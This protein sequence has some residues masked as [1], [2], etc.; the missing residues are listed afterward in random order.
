M[1]I[2][3]VIISVLAVILFFSCFLAPVKTEAKMGGSNN[4]IGS[5]LKITR[6]QFLNHLYRHSNDGYYLGTR[7]FS[8]SNWINLIYPNGSPRY[9]GFTGMNCAGWVSRALCDAGA[10]LNP[11][12]AWSDNGNGVCGA[13]T[14]LNYVA[15]TNTRY[16]VYES[17]EEMIYDG[18]LRKGDIIMSY[19]RVWFE[20]ADTHI[21][22]FWGNNAYDDKIWHQ[23]AIGNNISEIRAGCANSR[24][25][26]FP[27]DAVINEVYPYD[28]TG[29]K[30]DEYYYAWVY[31]ENGKI[32]WSKNG[33]VQK[34]ENGGW[35]YFKNGFLDWSANT[36]AQVNGQGAWWLVRGGQIDW[37]FNGFIKW[38][39][40]WLYVHNGY[41]DY[42]YTGLVYFNGNWFYAK[43]G[44]VD[45]SHT[46]LE[47]YNGGWFYVRNGVIDWKAHTFAPVKGTD[48]W[49]YVRNG[50]IDWGYKGLIKWGNDWL[51]VQKG[52]ADYKYAGLVYYSGRWFYV[53]DGKVN[54]AHTG[55]EYYN[56]GWF[57]VRNGEIDWN[58]HTF[59]SVEGTDYWFYVRNGQIDWGYK[60]LIKWGNDWLFVQKGYADYKYTGL[61]YYNGRWFYVDDG[62]VDWS[63]T[64]LT[65][66][67][68]AWYY[69]NRGELDWTYTGTAE[70]QGDTYS[71]RKGVAVRDKE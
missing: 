62:K 9:D 68:N 40:D 19:P 71:V 54:W 17:K 12:L 32:D 2:K 27:F 33:L 22:I 69:V 38:G 65:E 41:V 61:V 49:F 16:Y 24:W 39:N 8:S 23:T 66:Y 15:H 11:I 63:Y 28:Y 7:F 36:F 37:G 48:Y 6:Q 21:G 56:G 14:W 57:Y 58:A 44:K 18:K 70:Y 10:D 5:A 64:G 3:K 30:F 45:W 13:S 20:G 51:F 34:K 29:V 67:G 46:G 47:Y 31:T 35:Y 42:D 26:L 43:D 1:R 25:Y 53:S 52:Y 55:L 50:Q 59:A 60:G 4:Y